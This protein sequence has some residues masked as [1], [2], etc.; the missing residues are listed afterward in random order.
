VP[1]RPPLEEPTGKAIFLP[2][3]RS[4]T[5]LMRDSLGSGVNEITHMTALTVTIPRDATPKFPDRCVV[6]GTPQTRR[7]PFSTRDA[8]KGR[9][10]WAGWRSF[11]LPCC[12]GCSSRLLRSQVSEG[13]LI[14]L[15]LGLGVAAFALLSS[16]GSKLLAFVGAGAVFYGGIVAYALWSRQHPPAFALEPRDDYVSFEFRDANQAR[17][18]ANLNGVSVEDASAVRARLLG[19]A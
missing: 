18:F 9:A 8:T 14:A 15:I 1:E 6:C 12:P 7:T 10:F 5:Q 16:I 13:L 2:C 4:S 17:E 19:S 11:D 3:G